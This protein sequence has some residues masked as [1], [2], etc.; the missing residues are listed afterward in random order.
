LLGTLPPINSLAGFFL[1]FLLTALIS[2]CCLRATDTFTSDIDIEGAL[3]KTIRQQRTKREEQERVAREVRQ[4]LARR[5]A[6]GDESQRREE[7]REKAE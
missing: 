3:K 7:R 6:G 2:I 1:Y 4:Q 5:E